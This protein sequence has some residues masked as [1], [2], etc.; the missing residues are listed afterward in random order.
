MILRFVYI[1]KKLL[2]IS[3]DDFTV[4]KL[5]IWE[6][7]HFIVL[8]SLNVLFLWLN[9]LVN[10]FIIMSPLWHWTK[11]IGLI[12]SKSFPNIFSLKKNWI[13]PLTFLKIWPILPCNQFPVLGCNSL[14]FAFSSYPHFVSSLLL[15]SC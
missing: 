14:N 8:Y 15:T 9:Q 10:G 1:I 4:E 11:S 12:P 2:H 6:I 3:W 5:T 13:C 7:E